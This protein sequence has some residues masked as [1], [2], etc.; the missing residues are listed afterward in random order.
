[1]RRGYDATLG[2][3]T[4]AEEHSVN[5]SNYTLNAHENTQSV[6]IDITDTMFLV[7]F[8]ESEGHHSTKPIDHGHHGLQ[9]RAPYVSPSDQTQYGNISLTFYPSTS[10]LL[11]QGSSYMLWVEEHLPLI[12][13]SAE[14]KYFENALKWC[15]LATEQ[16]I[17]RN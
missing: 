5:N 4:A 12:Y 6:T 14:A 3:N 1:M 11:V 9:L 7:I 2:L 13:H 15:N 8:E 17:G 10:R 16:H